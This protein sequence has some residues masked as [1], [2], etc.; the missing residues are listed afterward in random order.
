MI[1]RTRKLDDLP[2]ALYEEAATL[3]GAVRRF[4]RQSESVTRSCGLTV[5]QY[6]LLL[7]IK[8]APGERATIGDLHRALARRQSGVT[9]LAR[10]AENL[11]LVTRELSRDDARV[12]YLRLTK[13]GTQRLAATA[14]ALGRERAVL[15][16]I[17]A[18]LEAS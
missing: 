1:A 18:E 8:V 3:R 15:L 6:E 7:L 4:L 16:A 10:R 17:L 9:Q 11:G 13:T 2:G 14:K 5:E 12:R